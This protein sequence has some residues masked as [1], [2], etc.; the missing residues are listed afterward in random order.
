[1]MSVTPIEGILGNRVTLGD[2]AGSVGNFGTILPLFF[3]VSLATGMSLSLMLFLCGVW[4]IITGLIYK[5][6]I[7]V[8]PLKAVAAVTIAGDV[9]TGQIAAAGILIGILFLLLGLSRKMQWIATHIPGSVIRGIQIALGLILFKS[10]IFD[11][12]MKDFPFFLLCLIVLG[13][14]MIGSRMGSLPDFSALIILGIGI[15]GM[16]ITE[17]IP[18]VRFPAIPGVIIPD[19]SEYVKATLQLVLP[20]IPL[21]LAN[22]ILATAL[23]A[24]EL[25][26]R[27]I[28]P[29]KLSISI[30]VMSLSSSIL[31]GF[32]MCHGAGGV[33]AHYRFGA[34]SGTAMIIGGL[35]LIGGAMFLTDPASVAAIPKGVFG[36]LLLAVAVELIRHGMKTD[37]RILTGTMAIIAIPAGIVVAFIVG[38]LFAGV[39][40]YYRRIAEKNS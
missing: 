27:K 15:T 20:Q 5:C 8:E 30:G 25:Y 32:P 10:A 4:Y 36:A 28:I 35:V 40:G 29:D 31:G 26:N 16:L 7:P 37:D 12:G 34:R 22:A 39:K 1:M 6:P 18:S 21:T 17:G 14:F 38:L 13:V 33:A 24:T 2:F 11:F 3:A 23:L 9:T 19:Y